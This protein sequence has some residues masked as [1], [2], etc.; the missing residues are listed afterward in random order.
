MSK[1]SVSEKVYIG[2]AE[3]PLFTLTVFII[4]GLRAYS[5]FG[6]IP[7]ISDNTR[8][9]EG[10]NLLSFFLLIWLYIP[11]VVVFIIFS[12]YEYRKAFFTRKIFFLLQGLFWGSVIV[13]IIL[14]L[15][16]PSGWIEWWLD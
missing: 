13:S 15:I 11:V 6:R 3:Y 5:A 14:L 9:L 2:L 16:M 10:N 4:L 1:F 7:T 12:R 8:F